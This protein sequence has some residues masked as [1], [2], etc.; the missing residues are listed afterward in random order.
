MPAHPDSA[1]NL[2]VLVPLADGFEETEVVAV[3]DVL[4]RADLRVTLAGLEPGPVTG[5]HALTL[6]PDAELDAVDL[7]SV[8]A[9]YLPGGMPGTTNL[10]SDS[11]VLELVRTLHGGGQPVAA[12]C[13]APRVLAAAGVID[14]LTVTSHPSVREQLGA[15]RVVDSPRVVADRGS[16]PI[17]TSQGPGTALEL[18]LE[19]VRRWVGADVAA[20]LAAAML[21]AVPAE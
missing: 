2:H 20:R 16:G 6:V 15:A 4:R 3:V 8:T 1:P 18:G 19:L 10:M 21:V 7:D 14:G 13:A 12:I 17:V 11:R 5:A 9:L